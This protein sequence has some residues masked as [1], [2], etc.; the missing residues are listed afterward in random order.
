M[1][2]INIDAQK[3]VALLGLHKETTIN[4]VN[5]EQCQ[6]HMLNL[7]VETKVFHRNTIIDT[8]HLQNDKID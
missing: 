2:P 1:N 5:V 7:Q 8:I 4:Y 6:A 3:E